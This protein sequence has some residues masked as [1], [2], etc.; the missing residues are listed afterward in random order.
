[1]SPRRAALAAGCL[2]AALA[3]GLAGCGG[4]VEP[5]EGPDG[6]AGGPDGAA[7]VGELMQVDLGVRP[8]LYNA[9]V[10]IALEEG[11]FAEEGLDVRVHM[12]AARSA[13]SFLMVDRGELDIMT[14]GIFLG[15]FNAIGEGSDV[16]LVADV[17]HFER[18]DCSPWA[19]V[20]ERGLAASG[21]LSGPASLRGLR[22]D[23][24][25][26]IVE[27]YFVDTYLRGGGLTLADIEIAEVPLASRQDAMNRA[28]IDMTAISEPWLNRILADGHV[29]YVNANEVVPDLQFAT[30]IFG[31][32][33]LEER[34]EAGRRFI[35]AY[36]RGV[37]RYREG[38]TARNVEI[39][40]SIMRLTEDEL[41][42]ACWPA[43]NEDA[44]V[45]VAT[46]QDFQRWG[47][48]QGLVDRVLAPEEYYDPS[49]LP[50]SPQ[51]VEPA[52]P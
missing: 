50:G 51:A 2:A 31:S 52:A 17:A 21:R 48:E 10:Y 28:S 39:L 25:P 16:R 43:V 18:D 23:M 26:N 15:L 45:E 42:R 3:A 13:Q 11:Y 47:V 5:A 32:R 14:G 12:V 6:V 24:N 7:G 36:V 30:L 33:L 44:E 27:G 29:A 35:A 8:F 9:P 40:S 41:E 22:I 38:K 19:L 46:L 1:M 49:F 20:A 4:G 37:Q 34:R